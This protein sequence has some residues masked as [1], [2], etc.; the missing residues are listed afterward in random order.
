MSKAVNPLPYDS[1]IA[2]NAADP[3]SQKAD[4]RRSLLRARQA[5]H[6]D[7]WHEK[8]DRLCVHLQNWPTFQ[9]AQTVLAFFSFRKE[10]ELRPLLFLPKRWGFPRC[11]GKTLTWHRWAPNAILPLQQ[12]AYGITEPHPRAPVISPHEVDLILIPAVACD[13][14]GYRLGYGGGFY[15]RMLSS[16]AWLNIPTIGIVFEFARLPK[17]PVAPWDRKLHGICTEAG[18]FMSG[19]SSTQ[20]GA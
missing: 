16:P 5:M 3:Q 6:P 11:E 2:V 13:V 4:L 8:S 12:G 1:F 20:I 9:Q 10:P 18:L 14:R 15:D 7:L 19:S 17:L